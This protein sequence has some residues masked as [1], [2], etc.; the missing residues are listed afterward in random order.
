MGTAEKSFDR[1]L[2]RRQYLRVRA[3]LSIHALFLQT[4]IAVDLD[5]LRQHGAPPLLD[6]PVKCL[7]YGDE[8]MRDVGAVLEAGAG[9]AVDFLAWRAAELILEGRRPKA[10]VVAKRRGEGFVALPE[11]LVDGRIERPW[12][13]LEGW[14]PPVDLA[15]D[16][17]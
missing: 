7:S 16:L 5:Y 12:E 2:M 11:I 6:A 9:S 1:A 10:R 8:T 13:Q 15:S 3:H 14:K 17:R 4:M